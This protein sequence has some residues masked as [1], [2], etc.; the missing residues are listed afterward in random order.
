MGGSTDQPQPGFNR[1]VSFRGQGVYTNPTFNVDGNRVQ[2]QGH[3][4]DLIT[5]YGVDWLRKERRAPFFLYLSHKAV[6]A[7]FEPAPRHR[8]AYSDAKIPHPASMADIKENYAGK[9]LWVRRQRH[10]WHGVDYMYHDQ[11]DFD[12]F[13]LDYNRTML[14]VD[15]S[16]G[17][18]LDTLN[19]LGL[20]E[21]TLIIFASDN[22]FLHGEHGLIDK[23]CMYEESIRVPMIAHCPEIIPAGQRSQRLVLNI[24]L[25]PT[26]LEAAGAPIPGS[27][28]GK[29]FLPLARGEH[30]KW[31]D[32]FLYEYF[33]EEAYP[34]T[35]TVLG[36]RMEDY[37]YMWYHGIF[38][39]NELYNL[40]EDPHEMVNLIDDASAFE[41][42]QDMHKR[43]QDLLKQLGA[44]RVPSFRV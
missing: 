22:G 21:S 27:V 30:P 16:V 35:P 37:K 3:V 42:R 12:K 44:T 10:S 34:Q 39:L 11:I 15:D 41:V 6:H 40:K 36:V 7:M 31:R 29:S 1:W 38:D 43:L 4:S 33:W 8:D 2:R 14:S 28:Q 5:E 32:A 20:L 25:G 17:Q 26:I 23:R 19:D 9:P 18:I 24:D 13:I